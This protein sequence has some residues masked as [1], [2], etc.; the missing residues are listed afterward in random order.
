M[1]AYRAPMRESHNYVNFLVVRLIN[2]GRVR[3]IDPP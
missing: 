3:V 2:E 1:S